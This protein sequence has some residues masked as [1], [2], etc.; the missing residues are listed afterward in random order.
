MTN[1]YSGG[2]LARFQDTRRS[3]VQ[4][5]IG[6]IYVPVPV[7]N[8]VGGPLVINASL[9]SILS[10]NIR[11][12]CEITQAQVDSGDPR[13]GVYYVF[14]ENATDVMAGLPGSYQYDITDL[15]PDTIGAGFS[16]LE[17]VPETKPYL[18]LMSRTANAAE[19]RIRIA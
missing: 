4:G 10:R 1:P 11:I 15:V 9:Q 18:L 7:L 13:E 8:D 19:V 5:P 2:A 3:G 14:A 16:V 12:T 6:G 17:V